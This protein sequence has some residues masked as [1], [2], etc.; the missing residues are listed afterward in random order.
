MTRTYRL[1]PIFSN[2]QLERKSEAPPHARYRPHE[3]RKVK[4][5][6]NSVE[7]ILWY[8]VRNVFLLGNL[9]L[10]CCNSFMC[11][12]RFWPKPVKYCPSGAVLRE[13]FIV[14][15][16]SSPTET[17]WFLSIQA[18]EDTPPPLQERFP[19]GKERTEE[20]NHGEYGE[21]AVTVDVLEMKS[22]FIDT[23]IVVEINVGKRVRL[24]PLYYTHLDHVGTYPVVLV[25]GLRP[26]MLSCVLSVRCC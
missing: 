24:V 6:H 26:Q 3:V 15:L 19:G 4:W 23:Y 20:A 1:L 13:V 8:C 5:L 10:H 12:Q 25:C 16:T 14:G 9:L 7:P 17:V 21:A 11:H 22:K 18:Y 2:S